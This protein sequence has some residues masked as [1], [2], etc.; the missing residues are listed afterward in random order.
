MVTYGCCG[1]ERSTLTLKLD[2][3]ASWVETTWVS[4]RADQNLI[5]LI[6]PYDVVNFVAH[7]TLAPDFTVSGGYHFKGITPVDCP[8]APRVNDLNTTGKLTH[9]T[10]AN[11]F[12]FTRAVE[13]VEIMVVA[14]YYSDEINSWH[15]SLVAAVPETFIA[16]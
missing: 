7:H 16:A 11:I 5:M 14:T 2:E 8:V 4:P 3:L 12:T 6:P 9:Q 10:G 13:K 1:S 15:L